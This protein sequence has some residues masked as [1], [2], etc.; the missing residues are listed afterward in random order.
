MSVPAP[1]L[2]GFL[3]DLADLDV[4]RA[5]PSFFM[6]I[7]DLGFF[8]GSDAAPSK[9][10]GRLSCNDLFPAMRDLD[11]LSDR[12]DFG[13]P[14]SDRDDDDFDVGLRGERGDMVL[15][16]PGDMSDFDDSCRNFIA[17]DFCDSSPNDLLPTDANRSLFRKSL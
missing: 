2:S 16:L 17:H 14:A 8:D 7:I 3:S 9:T 12:V 15:L 6:F 1:A 10:H 5:D 4:I 13:V 11:C